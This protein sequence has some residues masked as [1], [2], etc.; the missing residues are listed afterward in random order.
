MRLFEE[1]IP[2]S[3]IFAH[4]VVVVLFTKECLEGCREKDIREVNEVISPI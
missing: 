2:L 1:I 3:R 4:C